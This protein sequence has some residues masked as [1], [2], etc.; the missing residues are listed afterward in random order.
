MNVSA[1]IVAGGKGSRMKRSVRKQYLSLAGVPVIVHTLRIFDRLDD[2]NDICLVVP[3]SDIDYCRSLIHEYGWLK[4]IRLAS[5]GKTRQDSVYHGIR[6]LENENG[7]VAIHDAVRPLVSPDHIRE[8]IQKT[9]ESGACILAIPAFDTLKQV[10]VSGG[11]EKTIER[12][13]I[14][15]AQTPQV[16][17]RELIEK[18]HELAREKGYSGTDDASLVEYY[19]H[20]VG[21]VRGSRQNIKITTSEDLLLAEAIYKSRPREG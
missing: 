13:S 18:A 21:V 20:A 19:G 1:V 16:F 7:I 9:R 15:L 17:R 3:K 5:G 4:E 10:D 14:W 12:D 2:I 11:I 6:S 8:C